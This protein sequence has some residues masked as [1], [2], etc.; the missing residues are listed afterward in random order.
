MSDQN[1]PALLLA[2]AYYKVAAHLTQ[3]ANEQLM[4]ANRLN[5][6][7]DQICEQKVAEEAKEAN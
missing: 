2:D 3:Y 1:H 7:A 6:Y 4:I 5:R